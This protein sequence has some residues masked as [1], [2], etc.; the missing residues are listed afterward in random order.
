M[1]SGAEAAAR[2]GRLGLARRWRRL[3]CRSALQRRAHALGE[4]EVG[5]QGAAAL[6]E[7]AAEQEGDLAAIDDT[8]AVG[9]MDL[10]AEEVTELVD[11]DVRATWRGAD[12]GQDLLRHVVEPRVVLLE[13][14]VQK[15]KVDDGVEV[16][17][18][19]RRLPLDGL[20]VL[21]VVLVE[22]R[23]EEMVAARVDELGSEET[24]RLLQEPVV[25]QVVLRHLARRGVVDL[26]LEGQIHEVGGL[27]PGMNYVEL[28]DENGV[29]ARHVARAML[30]QVAR[31][32]LRLVRRELVRPEKAFHIPAFQ[33]GIDLRI[34]VDQEVAGTAVALHHVRVLVD[35]QEFQDGVDHAVDGRGEIDV[36]LVVGVA[37]P[38]LEGPAVG[39]VLGDRAGVEDAEA[40]RPECHDVHLLLAA[41]GELPVNLLQVLQHDDAAALETSGLEIGGDLAREVVASQVRLTDQHDDFGARPLLHDIGDAR[42]G[43]CIA[44][45]DIAQAPA[46]LAVNPD[47]GEA[48]LAGD[49]EQAPEGV[50][51]VAPVEIVPDILQELGFADLPRHET[52]EDLLAARIHHFHAEHHLPRARGD[53]PQEAGGEFLR[54]GKRVVVSD[55]DDV[56]LVA[57]DDQ[58]VKGRGILEA[59]ELLVEVADVPLARVPV[60]PQDVLLEARD[61]RP[62]QGDLLPDRGG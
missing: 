21:A 43:M 18:G 36:V 15:D 26:P 27:L 10:L 20:P 4:I 48:V 49:I 39:L 29:D 45:A 42:P 61:R 31:D 32:L 37:L 40:I 60:D 23:L 38:H 14:L 13:L 9:V 62:L 56:R 50:P 3:W 5:L 57:G 25:E 12:A 16:L 22:R 17:V 2:S 46:R 53:L 19:V 6:A 30:R 51:V 7:G 52:I 59:V 41:L 54:S 8:G 33:A 47:D 28:P 34:D 44:L 11:Q 35:T 1:R 24:Q 58:V 55:V